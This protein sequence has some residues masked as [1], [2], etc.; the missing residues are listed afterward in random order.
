MDDGR[1]T[2]CAFLL[3]RTILLYVSKLDSE[4]KADEV[5]CTYDNI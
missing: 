2:G 4:L 3:V 1:T 5:I